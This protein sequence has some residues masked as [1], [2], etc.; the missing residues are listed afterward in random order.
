MR[1]IYR[2]APIS[3]DADHAAPGCA[4]G[5]FIFAL[6]ILTGILLVLVYLVYAN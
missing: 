6:L 3:T 2:Y 4:T 1:P 5:L